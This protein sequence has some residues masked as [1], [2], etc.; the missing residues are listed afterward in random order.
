MQQPAFVRALLVCLLALTSSLR[1]DPAED[2]FNFAEGLFIQQDYA[3]AIEEY[4][5]FLKQFPDH[6]KAGTAALRIG[7]CH[8]RGN[9]YD[10]AAPAYESA[11]AKYPQA[12]DASLGWYNLG[13][14]YLELKQPARALPAFRAAGKSEQA[15]LREESAVG[16][17]VCL[18]QLEKWEEAARHYGDFLKTWPGSSHRA[19]LLFTL[20]WVLIQDGRHGEAIAPLTELIEAFPEYAS[21]DRARL[22][23]S[24]AYTETGKFA[25]ATAL[26]KGMSTQGPEAEAATLRLAWTQFKAGQKTEAAGTFASFADRFA[27]SGQV[28]SAL[29]NGGIACYD[30]GAYARAIELFRRLRKERPDS[31]EAADAGLWLGISLY[32]AQDYQAAADELKA[33]IEKGQAAGEQ[34]AT[35]AYTRA[36]ALA[37]L[38]DSKAAIA[39]FDGMIAA[40]PDSRYVENARYSKANTQQAAGELEGAVATLRELLEKHPKGG[41][42]QHALFALGEYLYRL[43][44]PKEVV[45]CLEELAKDAGYSRRAEVLYRLGWAYY[46]LGQ[47]QAAHDTFATLAGLDSPFGPEAAYMVGRAAESLN[48]PEAAIA[49]YE[50]LAAK[51]GDNPF[52]EKALYRLGFLYPLDKAVG[53]LEAYRAR[54]PQGEWLS[55]MELKV[56]EQRF[57]AGEVKEAEAAYRASL[58][59]TLSPELS[60]SAWYGLGWCL[61]KQDKAAEAEAAFVKVASGKPEPGIAQ[62]ALLQRAEIAYGRGDDAAAAG[63]FGQVATAAGDVGERA[64]YML[65]WCALNRDDGAGAATWF[66]Q[67]LSRFPAGKYAVDSTIRLASVVRQQGK[68]EQAR[69]LLAGI[70]DKVEGER[71]EEV[72]HLYCDALV[73]LKDWQ[74]LIAASE[75]LQQKFPESP[76]QY[77]RA[78]RLGLAYKELG[79][80]DKAEACFR[81][82][83]ATT[84]TIEAAK[85]QFNLGTLYYARKEYLEAGKQFLRVEM[86]Y[87][88]P[89]LSP[90]ALYHAIDAF[91]QA[92][93]KD[94]GRLAVHLKKLHQTYPDSPWTAKADELL[95]K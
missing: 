62:D 25:E 1:A 54:F 52:I 88:Y 93:G 80:L 22:A 60:A 61:L 78:F 57:K 7:E 14:S 74:T 32:H 37:A 56:A 68:F 53:N 27:A 43:K 55:A 38:G 35:A 50:R 63:L 89:E 73:S 24:D 79:V 47:F 29:F 30:E 71:E 36:E 66:E 28:A 81:D 34:L 12:P 87:N 90:K 40:Y 76:R 39:A 51:E 49:V 2:Q 70:L 94:S 33:V 77:L 95:A 21:L 64:V 67:S 3:S 20:G 91:V 11:L 92:E 58:G 10:K 23:L 16:A 83:I 72:L 41:L 13:R 86:L 15:T 19:D 84:E 6:G 59:K 85:A 9:A 45:P 75:R 26:L 44:Q 8:F 31:R 65:G 4:E 17:G 46:D 82:T 69:D 48:Q 42:R 5:G 18:V